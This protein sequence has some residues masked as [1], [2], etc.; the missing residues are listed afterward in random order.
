MVP[1]AWFVRLVAAVRATLPAHEAEAVLADGGRRT[2]AY[3]AAHRI[4][5]PL[6][7]LLARLPARW[8]VALLLRAFDRHA[9][10]FAG[11]GRYRGRGNTITLADAPT[12]RGGPPASRRRGGY[13]AAAFEGLLRLAAPSASVREITCQACGDD[14]CRFAITFET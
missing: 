7:F 9:W 3:V 13:Y 4:P 11:A 1:E 12:C 10:T 14:R 6:R 5:A 8:G 2:A